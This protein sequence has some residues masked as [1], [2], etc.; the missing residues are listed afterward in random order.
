MKE[1]H[2]PSF[3]LTLFEGELLCHAHKDLQQ[4][5]DATPTESYFT[6]QKEENQASYNSALLGKRL[7]ATRAQSRA[8]NKGKAISHT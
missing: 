6:Q 7:I 3:S 4:S 8:K 5:K 1:G 2:T